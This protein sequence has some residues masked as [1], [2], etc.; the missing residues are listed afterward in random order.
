MLLLDRTV[1]RKSSGGFT[2]VFARLVDILK[3]GKHSTH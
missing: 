3:L 1:T 2:Y